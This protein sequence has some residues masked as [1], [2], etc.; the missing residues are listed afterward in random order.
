MK[1]PSKNTAIELGPSFVQ[2]DANLADLHRARGLESDAE[3]TL[4]EGLRL[5]PKSAA[6][7]HALRL[8]LVRQLVAEL[9]GLLRRL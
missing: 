5:D 9:G 7:H 2:A 6:L 4:W 1:T 8:A 3:A